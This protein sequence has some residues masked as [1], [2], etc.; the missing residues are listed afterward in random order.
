MSI[1]VKPVGV[2]VGII[3]LGIVA[4]MV[5]LFSPK[6]AQELNEQTEDQDPILGI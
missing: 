2:L 3:T 4:I 5:L 6:I 1:I